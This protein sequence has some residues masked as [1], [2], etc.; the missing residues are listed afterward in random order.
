MTSKPRK[1]YTDGSCLVNPDGPGGWAFLVLL[2][3]GYV[4]VCGGDPSTTNNRMEL[5]AVIKALQDVPDRDVHIYSD[6]QLV[7]KCATGEWRR[8]AN[9]NLWKEYDKYALSHN[10]IWTWVK[11]HNGDEYNEIVDTYAREEAKK[12]K[13]KNLVI[14]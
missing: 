6:S 14:Q 5:Q 1:V 13:I 3:E 8:K 7:I 9:I 10:I 11:G 12:Y 4:C 2:D